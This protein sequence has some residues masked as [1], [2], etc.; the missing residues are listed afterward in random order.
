MFCI[1]ALMIW[2][3]FLSRLNNRRTNYVNRNP[4]NIVSLGPK[5]MIILFDPLSNTQTI[6]MLQWIEPILQCL[7]KKEEI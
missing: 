6:S 7:E 2:F 4:K 1:F 3:Q 5:S